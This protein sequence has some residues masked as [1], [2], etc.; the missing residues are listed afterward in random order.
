MGLVDLQAAVLLAPAIVTLLGDLCLTARYGLNSN[1]LTVIT[2][3]KGGKRK[4]TQRP[5]ADLRSVLRAPFLGDSGRTF[6]RDYP[7]LQM[8]EQ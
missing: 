6:I 3:E 2:S 1:S 8:I 7:A 4:L 5:Q